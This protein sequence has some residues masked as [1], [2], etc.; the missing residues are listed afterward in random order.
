MGSRDIGRQERELLNS[1]GIVRKHKQVRTENSYIQE[2]R[3]LSLK[4]P[5]TC[6]KTGVF[7]S[8]FPN[9]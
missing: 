5:R 8:N 4:L 9:P 3:S 6:I 2:T 7:E 1:E